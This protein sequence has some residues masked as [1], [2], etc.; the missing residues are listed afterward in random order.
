M[1]LTGEPVEVCLDPAVA[2]L[3]PG[4]AARRLHADLGAMVIGGVASLF[5]QSLHPLAVAGVVQ[6]SN[7]RDDPLGRLER[8]AR[9]VATV[10]YGTAAEAEAAA[11]RV[12]AIHRRVVGTTADGRPYS[13][14]DGS[15]VTFVHVAEIA[16]FAEAARRFG[17]L[18][19]ELDE[20]FVD[21]YVAET[22]A[23]AVALGGTDVPRT[24]ASLATS[25][26][27]YRAGLETTDDTR[28]IR[29]FLLAGP[30]ASVLARGGYALVVSAAIS[31][32]PSWARRM[33]GLPLLPLVGAVAVDPAARLLASG[34][35]LVVEA[36]P[37]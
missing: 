17:T 34:L 23:S 3:P 36:P 2:A 22:A 24:G 30:P 15:L 9:Y 13:A 4:C 25:L 29:R 37:A 18:G 12:R 35:R 27:H 19:A 6:H 32:L 26:E 1:G 20:A 8:T 10:T 7:Y 28:A 16:M 31:C 33:L 5:L 14:L 21:R 11:R